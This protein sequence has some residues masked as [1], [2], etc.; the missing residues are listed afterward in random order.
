V[1]NGVI[2]CIRIRSHRTGVGLYCIAYII[3]WPICL[4]K[5]CCRHTVA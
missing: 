4:K 3:V 1:Q 2:Q 5:Y